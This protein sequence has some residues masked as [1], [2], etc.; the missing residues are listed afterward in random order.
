MEIAIGIILFLFG[1]SVGIGFMMLKAKYSD[2]SATTK[3]QLES[4]MQQ[5]AQMKLDWQDSLA[6]FKSLA[7]SMHEISEQMNSRVIEA[8]RLHFEEKQTPAFPFF[9]KEATQILQNAEQDKRLSSNI[10]DQPVDYPEAA[11]GVF[12]GNTELNK[13]RSE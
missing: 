13:E 1:L 4:C 2:G 8:E 5:N 6:S 10:S 9:S 3:Q 7:T 11:S 12:S